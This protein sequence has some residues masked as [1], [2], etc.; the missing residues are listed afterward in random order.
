VGNWL[1]WTSACL[2]LLADKIFSA[3][4][5]V[6]LG[7]LPVL[8]ALDDDVMQGINWIQAGFARHAMDILYSSCQANFIS[9]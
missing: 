2:K 5:G 8:D 1:P 3:Y 4:F 6:V 7:N 9:A